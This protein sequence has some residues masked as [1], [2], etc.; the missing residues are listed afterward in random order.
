MGACSHSTVADSSHST[1]TAPSHHSHSTITAQSQ[2]VHSAFRARS[3]TFARVPGLPAQAWFTAKAS[4]LLMIGHTR[5][6]VRETFMSN[7]NTSGLETM[8]LD[9]RPPVNWRHAIG[10]QAPI[11]MVGKHGKHACLGTEKRMP[12][13]ARGGVPN[14]GKWRQL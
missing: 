1:V 13:G 4:V 11:S 6:M 10:L 3:Q 5:S 8:H 14:G 12:H 9:G 7:P 2:H